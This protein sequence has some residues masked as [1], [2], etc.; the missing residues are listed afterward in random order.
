MW[1]GAPLRDKNPGMT[2]KNNEIYVE[3]SSRGYTM[4]GM[5][6]RP[7]DFSAARRYPAVM[8]WHGFTGT[9]VEPHRLFVKAARRLAAAGIVTARF[10]FVGSGESDGDFVEASPSTEIDDAQAVLSWMQAQAGGDRTRLGL[11][12]LSLGGLV[13]ACA[14]ARSQ[15]V[16]ALCLWAATAHIDE[17]MKDRVT[18]EGA[19]QLEKFGFFDYGGNRISRAFVESAASVDPLGE[20]TKFR[21]AALVI[22]GTGDSVV[23]VAEAHEYAAALHACNPTLHL[24]PDADHTFN[25][26]EW[27]TE[28]IETTAQWLARNL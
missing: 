18:P 14:A 7:A 10:D 2:S 21:G 27:E 11:I 20:V 19:Q 13:S 4:R 23:P 6:H 26:W 17:R 28:L 16:K 24:M 8:L 15:Q 3:V 1:C 9:R 25:R 12:G 22:H 5:L